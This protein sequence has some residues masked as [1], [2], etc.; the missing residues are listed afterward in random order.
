ME[1]EKAGRSDECATLRGIKKW[2]ERKMEGLNERLFGWKKEM[3]KE[4][5][6]ERKNGRKTERKK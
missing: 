3:R 6:E 4:R 5:K 2:R 1:E